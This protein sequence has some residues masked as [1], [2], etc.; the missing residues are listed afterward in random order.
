VNSTISGGEFCLG[1]IPTA[2]GANQGHRGLIS[3]S[4]YFPAA[5]STTDRQ[6]LE[7][8]QSTY[9]GIAGPA[10]VTLSNLPSVFVTSWLDQ[11]GN[12]N[13]LAQ[14]TNS[15]QPELMTFGVICRI[16]G[17]P[18]IKGT[19]ANQ[20]NLTTIFPTAQ[21]GSRLTANGIV[22]TDEGSNG[23][24]RIMSL[25]N[26]LLNSSDWSNAANCNINQR[27]TNQFFIERNGVSPGFSAT[28]GVPFAFSMRFS[29]TTRQLFNNGVGTARCVCCKASIRAVKGARPS[30]AACRN[31]GCT[32]DRC[33]RHAGSSSNPTRGPT[34]AWP[35]PARSTHCRPGAPISG[36]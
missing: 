35:S 3:E 19:N 8:S 31:T 25:G 15:R 28:I 12:D 13:L 1:N 11:S 7:F 22:Q 34:T 29:G 9:Y 30:P 21:V 16:N 6:R 20:T 23:N 10:P 17:R 18:A 4:I 5:L 32:C 33:P 24:R 36:M 27:N 26:D 2:I 14:V